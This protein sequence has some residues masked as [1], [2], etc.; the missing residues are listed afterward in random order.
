MWAALVFSA[1]EGLLCRQASLLRLPRA[2]LGWGCLPQSLVPQLG[3]GREGP[4]GPVGKEVALLCLPEA[5]A[6][7]M[8]RRQAGALK[9]CPE[10]AFLCHRPLL[11]RGGV[12]GH[13]GGRGGAWRACPAPRLSRKS[14]KPVGA[15]L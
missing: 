10:A 1:P 2:A 7:L 8:V 4:P 14:W 13:T 12:P 3:Q 5:S 15:R 11:R 9:A 6:H